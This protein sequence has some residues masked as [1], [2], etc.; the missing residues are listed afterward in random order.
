MLGE[1]NFSDHGANRLGASAL[2]QG[3]ADGVKLALKQDIIPILADRPVYILA[4]IISA[5][6]CF[7]AFSVI[8]MGPEVS[9]FGTTTNLQLTDFSVAVLFVLAA[10]SIGIYGI[11]LA[12]WS[13]GST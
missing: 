3:L 6:T 11:V 12:S 9:I 4:P 2:M 1:A 8:P 7:L 13:S 5:I 10:A